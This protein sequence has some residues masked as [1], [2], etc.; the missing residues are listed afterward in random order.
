MKMIS[1]ECCWKN[2]SNPIFTN[3]KKEKKKLGMDLQACIKKA[4]KKVS[5]FFHIVDIFLS[6]ICYCLFR[7]K[8]TEED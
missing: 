1:N 2:N 5:D 3:K 6:Q 7:N 4:V 8:L